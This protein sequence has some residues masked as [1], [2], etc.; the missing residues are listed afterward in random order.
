MA[1]ASHPAVFTTKTPHV[2]PAQTYL[3][4]ATWRRYQLSQLINQVLSLPQPIPFDFLMRGKVVKTSVGEWCAE[5]DVGE[6]ETLEIEYIESVMPPQRMTTIPQ[7]DWISSVSCRVPGRLLAASYDT[8][9]H[10]FDTPVQL[11]PGHAGP[12]TSVCWVGGERLLASA[13]Q[14]GTAR[15]VQVPQP[16]EGRPTALASLHLH[17]APLSSVASDKDGQFVMTASWDTL[18]GIWDTRIPETDQTVVDEVVDERK[19]RRKV[20]QADRPVRKAPDG[21]MRSHTGRI[22]RALFSPLSQH[23]AYSCGLDSTI[24]SWDTSVGICTSTLTLSEKPLVD[25]AILAR[26][27]TVAVASTDR[28]VGAYDVRRSTTVVP[29]V[30]FTQ[31]ALPSTVA[32]HP[33]DERRMLSGSYDGIVRVWD[34]RSA[35]AA[36]AVFKTEKGG[37]VL[38]VDWG[39]GVCALGGEDGVEVWKVGESGEPT[40]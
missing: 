11:I 12:V 8:H 24:R 29:V 17:T 26:G 5:H 20:A 35:K 1:D 7:E 13:S 38:S 6:E 14:D 2:L 10:L 39:D 28:T 27:D 34:L 22:S 33:A 18:I 16:H 31:A 30:S 23:T 36:V 25:L 37:K 15:L 40:P 19:K 32:A 21:V 9:V 4:P 3:I